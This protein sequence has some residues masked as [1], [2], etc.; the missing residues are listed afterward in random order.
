MYGGTKSKDDDDDEGGALSESES[1][2]SSSN[3]NVYNRKNFKRD[4]KRGIL[5]NRFVMLL[6]IFTLGGLVYFYQVR[7]IQ[8]SKRLD[9]EHSYIEKLDKI[10]QKQAVVIDR[11]N[12]SVSNADILKRVNTLDESLHETEI[13]MSQKLKDTENKIETL[14]NTT[15]KKLDDSIMNAEAQIH[16]EVIEV[17][18]NI[19]VYQRTTQDQFSME[20]SFM[21]YQIAGTFTLLSLLISMWHMTDHLRKM[22]EP[23]VQRKILAILWMCPIYSITSWLSL[24]FVSLSEYLAILKDFYEAYCIYTFLSLIIAI[25]GRGDRKAVVTKLALRADHLSP[26]FRLCGCFCSKPIY[27]SDYALADAVLMQCQAFAMQF[28]FLRP[29]ISVLNFV[30]DKTHYEFV[31]PQNE[32]VIIPAYLEPK[33]YLSVINNISVFVAFSGLLKIYHAVQEDLAWYRPFPKFLAIKLV[34]FMTFWQ[35]LAITIL[36]STTETTH[37]ISIDEGEDQGQGVE[38]DHW[39]EQAQNFLICLEMLLF[40]IAHFYVFPTSEWKPGYRPIESKNKFG[41]HMALRDFLSDMKLVLAGGNDTNKNKKKKKKKKE[42]LSS[43]STHTYTEEDDDNND[44]DVDNNNDVS[45]DNID[46]ENQ[47]ETV[48]F[49]DKET[50]DDEDIVK[51]ESNELS[52]SKDSF[53][54][55]DDTVIDV[56]EQIAINKEREENLKRKKASS[57]S[58]DKEN[59]NENNT[60]VQQ[61]QDPDETFNDDDDEQEDI[62]TTNTT[63]D[64]ASSNNNETKNNNDHIMKNLREQLSHMKKDTNLYQVSQ[65]VLES[66]YFKELEKSEEELLKND[67]TGAEVQ[68]VKKEHEQEQEKNEN[69][70]LSD[71]VNSSDYVVVEEQNDDD[72]DENNNITDIIT[73]E[74]PSEDTP[75]LGG[76]TGTGTIHD[77]QQEQHQQSITPPLLHQYQN[78]QQ[79]HSYSSNTASDGDEA[80]G[81]LRESIF[82]TLGDIAEAEQQKQ[83]TGKKDV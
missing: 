26:P 38:P 13:Q 41:D 31:Q 28:V 25:L 18:Q 19:D 22:H 67:E 14:L 53:M 50:E 73:L 15:T 39:A 37:K 66:E 56:D 12:Q 72:D 59:E 74:P 70:S 77:F 8:M 78:Q 35:G 27:E 34:V 4:L 42:L 47:K 29:L 58:E 60:D 10:I 62:V 11:F 54:T 16:Q 1:L 51:L 24:V 68:S 71:D 48:T 6:I 44:K 69:E 52:Q 3:N 80:A 23:F 40:S 5:C 9:D 17:K 83:S 57:T 64:T 46:I 36:A 75:L 55:L 33:T 61:Q 63:T 43:E 79:Q 21:I 7:C 65:R 2:L 49:D 81:I 82:T 30:V 20:N 45:D 32:G 76:S